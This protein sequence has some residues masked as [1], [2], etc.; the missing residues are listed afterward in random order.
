MIKLLIVDDD[1]WIREGLRR[2]IRWEQAGIEVAGTAADGEEAL[3]L[4]EELRPDLVLTDIQMPFLDGLQLAERINGEYP[5]TKVVFLTGYDDFSY[6]KQALRLQAADYILKYEDN[7]VILNAVASAASTLLA[8]KRGAEQARKSQAL[9]QNK[10]F[11][12]LF[13]GCANPEW[14]RKELD[15]LGIAAPEACFQVAV[16]QPED[17]RRFA[18]AGEGDNAELLLFSIHNICSELESGE[19]PYRYP[20]VYNNRVNLLFNLPAPEDREGAA[21]QLAEHLGEIRRTLETCLKL[22]ISVGLGSCREGIGR[23]AISYG[24]AL[25]AAQLKPVIGEAGVFVSG[26]IR[27]SQNSH[28]TLLKEMEQYMR[29]H[30]HEEELNLTAIAGH[31]HISSAYASTLFKK[32]KGMNLSEYLIQLRIDKAAEL[33]STTDAKSYEVSEQVGYRNPQYFSVLFKKHYGKSPSEYRR[34]RQHS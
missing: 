7:E 23:I 4:M 13:E 17:N 29:Q 24:E 25:N 2:N 3:K 30:F 1:M 31:V 18:R 33:L 22:Q 28:H 19:F 27:H 10:F 34:D 9:I 26:E 16:I 5:G 12:E 14:A 15:N 8:D 20:A 11:A 21:E 6:A 32:Y